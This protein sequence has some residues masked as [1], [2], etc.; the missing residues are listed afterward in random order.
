[1]SPSEIDN[2][3][4]ENA[5]LGNAI[6]ILFR[7]HRRRLNIASAYVWLWPPIRLGQIAFLPDANGQPVAYA[8]WAYLSEANSERMA[9]D[10]VKYLEIGEWNEG[11]DLWITDFVAPGGNARA[12]AGNLKRILDPRHKV[13]RGLRPKPEGGLS[14][15]RVIRR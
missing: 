14:R 15:V 3:T 4:Y 5:R 1:M 13:A 2:A 9:R 12:L 8:T 11:A 6:Q 7:T 10:E